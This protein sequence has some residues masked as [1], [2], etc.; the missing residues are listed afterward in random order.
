MGRDTKFSD[1]WLTKQDPNKDLI[2]DWCEKVA[3]DPLSARC[4]VCLKTFSVSNMG[5]MQV[6]SHAKGQKHRMAM[7]QRK[8]QTLFKTIP[9]TLDCAE[10]SA[11]CTVVCTVSV[12]PQGLAT[13]PLRA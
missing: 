10:D 4:I 11:S 1:S 9:S 5:L 6:E 2:S 7:Q 8:G 3:N 13:L 12:L